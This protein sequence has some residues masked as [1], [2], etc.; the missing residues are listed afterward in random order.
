ME[1]LGMVAGTYFG[2]LAMLAVAGIAGGLLAGLLGIGGGIVIVPVLY[3]VFSAAEVDEAIRL[4]VAVATSLATIIATSIVS[5]RSHRKHESVDDSLLRQ[6]WLPILFGV[7]CG[8]AIG[9]AVNGKVLALVFGTVALIVSVR[10]ILSRE[11]KRPYD[12]FPNDLTKW[13]TGI[14]VGL[15]SALMGIGGGTLSVPILSTFGFD[16]RRA[17]GTAAAIGLIIAVPA[18]LG[19]ILNGWNVA[20][21]PPFSLGYMNW[22]GALILVPL[23]MAAAP[24][25]AKLAHSIPRKAL[26]ICFGVFLGVSALR[27]LYD[28]F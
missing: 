13:A 20:N 17:V 6:W 21:L 19:Y 27:I 11:V 15:L 1:M 24:L 25:G 8:T 9:G 7:V 16:I 26:Q 28:I 2:W 4:K 23:T 3:H 10:M 18:T 14:S 12:G 5:V 22:A